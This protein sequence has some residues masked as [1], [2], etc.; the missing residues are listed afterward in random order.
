MGENDSLEAKE[1]YLSD[2]EKTQDKIENFDILETITNVGNDEVFTPMQVCTEMLDSL[3]KE[4]WRNPNYRWLNPVTKNGIF[5][6]EIAIRLNDGLKDIIPNE[7]TR[8]K[9]II[10]DMIFS[11]G[12]T[13]FTSLVA[14]RTLYYCAYA[15]RK[16]DG[17]YD[18]V[19]GHS[20]NGYAIGN[21]TWFDDEEGNIKTPKAEHVFDTK[22]TDAKCVFC[23]IRRDSKYN[24]P[25][26]I[27]HYAYEFIHQKD[28]KKYIANAF[29]KGDEKMK[30]DIIIGNPPYQLNDGGANA[31]ARPIYQYF[32]ERALELDPSYICMII[33]ARW[34]AGG[35]GLDEFRTKMLNDVHIKKLVDYPNAKECFPNF[36]ISGGVC[37]FVR[38]KS[39]KGGCTF[40]SMENPSAPTQSLR[41]LNR[42]PVFVRFDLG[43]QIIAK[44]EKASQ[45]SLST[46]VNS[47]NIFGFESKIRGKDKPYE[48]GY[49][50]YSS[51]GVSYIRKDEIKKNLKLA[52][53]FK[54]M[55]S[56]TTAEHANEPGLDGKYKILSTTK[57]LNPGEVVTDSYIIVG[58][59]KTIE[60]TKN[61]L[62]FLRTKFCRFLISLST[63]SI[64][65]T[66]DCFQFVPLMDFSRTWSDAELDQN[67]DLSKSEVEFINSLIKDY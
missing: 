10:R 13:K 44:V 28:L 22:G 62:N 32:I 21:G 36:S 5:E 65:V 11:I 9:H 7:L 38:D 8:K 59:F 58:P 18:P 35:K 15:N 3:P 64:N 30:F 55:V 29:F 43:E 42:F 45:K 20:L 1:K 23:G 19:D 39:Y 63:S 57:A 41:K 52:D 67:F 61:A 50:L 31:S 56:K 16:D 66:K 40:V 25:S 2:V 33:P 51:D 60:Q 14:R 48:N 37:Y 24:D 47:R 4:V 6:R 49:S 54:I 17:K 26:Q 34:Y 12:E 46:I 27:E 53:S